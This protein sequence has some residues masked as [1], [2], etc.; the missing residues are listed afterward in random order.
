[1]K[2]LTLIIAISLLLLSCSEEK[3]EPACIESVPFHTLLHRSLRP[4]IDTLSGFMEISDTIS[5]EEKLFKYRIFLPT[6]FDTVFKQLYGSC[7]YTNTRTVFMD[8][9]Y[10]HGPPST[11][12]QLEADDSLFYVTVSCDTT[13]NQIINETYRTKQ[14]QDRALAR[15]AS[16]S[17]ILS[18]TNYL[19]ARNEK[20]RLISEIL[21]SDEHIVLDLELKI[22]GTLFTVTVV[23][24]GGQSIKLEELKPIVESFE[25]KQL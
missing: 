16:K 13:N 9:S 15:K 8:Q 18:D 10:T 14:Q 23:Y 11:Y 5:I 3:E 6:T 2:H 7:T 22:E 1:M 12:I 19:V 17:S 20:I 21:Y 24:L 4:S 25:V